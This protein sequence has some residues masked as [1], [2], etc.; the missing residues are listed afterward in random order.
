MKKE[1]IGKKFTSG[2]AK[3]EI[4]DILTIKNNEWYR[5]KNYTDN[6]E[7]EL[8]NESRIEEYLY[9]QF[10][11]Y[12]LYVKNIN[13]INKQEERRKLEKEKEE[14]EKIKY[15]FCHGFTDNNTDMQR[16]KILKTLNKLIKYEKKIYTKKEWIE[17]LLTSKNIIN[18]EEKLNT[19]R[20]S[21][22]KV[23]GCYQK[24]VDKVE[25]T[26]WYYDNEEKVG[27]NINKTEYDYA[28]YL[29]KKLNIKVA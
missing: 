29:L 13:F 2:N 28:L 11:Y 20:Y 26:I 12:G 23:A 16:G 4:I 14:Q 27:N 21:S 22:R 1:F 9:N 15:N 19:N 6:R 5:V 17:F 10:Y 18:V 8:F 7:D 24:L 3:Y 25:Y